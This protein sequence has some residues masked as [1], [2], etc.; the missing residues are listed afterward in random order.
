MIDNSMDYLDSGDVFR[1]HQG[2]D[3]HQFDTLEEHTKEAPWGDT[4]KIRVWGQE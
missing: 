3:N 2:V 4:W 1:F